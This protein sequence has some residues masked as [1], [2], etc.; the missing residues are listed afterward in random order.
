MT[1]KQ[2][3]SVKTPRVVTVASTTRTLCEALAEMLRLKLHDCEAHGH[4]S[5]SE[6]RGRIHGGDFAV[7]S[8]KRMPF[9]VFLSSSSIGCIVHDCHARRRC[10]ETSRNNHPVDASR[11]MSDAF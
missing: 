8:R 2:I 5:V 9:A 6:C 10:E 1:V 3:G 4:C 7:V 11:R